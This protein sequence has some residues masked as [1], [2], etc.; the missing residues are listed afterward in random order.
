MIVNN[1][2]NQG[3]D[4]L[5]GL[6]GYLVAICHYQWLV[7]KVNYYEYV[8][9]LFVEFFFILSGFVLAPQIMKIIN[10]KK[11]IMVFFKRRWMRTIPL[12]VLSLIL[13]SLI[14]DNIFSKDFFLYLF[15]LNKTLPNILDIDYFAVAW[16]LAVEE[17][18]Y[19]LFPLFIY[20][21]F[22]NENYKINSIKL[23]IS[24]SLLSVFLSFF[25]DNNF[26][27]TGTFLRIDTILCGFLLAALFL[28]NKINLNYILISMITLITL[29]IYYYKLN[30]Y[31]YDVFY[32]KILFLVLLKLFAIFT[33]LLFYKID[34]GKKFNMFT[35]LIANQTYSIYLLHLPLIYL[36]NSNKIINLNL[37]QYCFFLFIIG[38]IVFLIFEK[39]ILQLRPK[40]EKN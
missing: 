19:L 8:S 37:V 30:L 40:Y 38:T 31:I 26:Y 17:Y 21:F 36:I 33:L 14:T 10:E 3:L 29:Y 27:R 22:N 6:C 13:V 20:L 24:L 7:N 39:P 5:R 35:K 32:L 9:I 11:H 12:Y 18:F 25:V 4:L 28:E 2:H 15:F 1:S 34:L 16:S 23:F